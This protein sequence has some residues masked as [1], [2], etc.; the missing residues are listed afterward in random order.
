MDYRVEELARQ[1]GVGVDTV[2]YYQ[3]RGL[4][5]APRREG[6]V[7]WYGEEHLR[8]V[9]RVRDLSAQGFTL[10]QVARLLED[11]GAASEPPTGDGPLL[12]ALLR[13]GVGPGR[14]FSRAELAAESGLPEPLLL[15]AEEAGLFQAVQMDGEPRYGEA[16]LA[17][18]RAGLEPVGGGLPLGELARLAAD[19]ARHVSEVAERAIE[20]FDEHVRKHPDGRQRPS[21]QVAESFEALLPQVTRLVALHFQRTVVAGALRRL[22]DRGDDAGLRDALAA[23]RDARMEVSVQ[24]R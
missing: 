3:G 15:A 9:Q 22:E 12:G 23:T 13:E 14:T 1:A 24:W 17:M 6:R 2:R 21:A 4:L 16:D 8:R 18:A 10:A 19:H 7:A 20:L 11:A 5:P